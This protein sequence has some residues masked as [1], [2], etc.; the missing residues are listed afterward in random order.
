MGSGVR[1]L[2]GGGGVTGKVIVDARVEVITR[3]GCGHSVLSWGASC[4]DD[5]LFENTTASLLMLRD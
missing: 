5:L 1:R 3:I 2:I 4:G